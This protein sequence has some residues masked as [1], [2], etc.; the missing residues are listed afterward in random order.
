MKYYIWETYSPG[1]GFAYCTILEG[2]T[3][4]NLDQM[5]LGQKLTPIP[6][7]LK[8]EELSSGDVGDSIGTIWGL[9]MVSELIAKFLPKDQVQLIPVN[10]DLFESQ[11]DYFLLAVEKYENINYDQSKLLY[12]DEIMPG[13]LDKVN[14]LILKDF[15]IGEELSIY[16]LEEIP[17][18][19]VVSEIL[20]LEI[21]KVSNCAGDFIEVDKYKYG[22]Y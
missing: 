5:A 6:K 4:E 22:Y 14:K 17:S 2:M 1:A 21:E 7:D 10:T 8:I 18:C 3:P 11:E 15:E 13:L 16:R 9:H 12:S 19:F 20:K